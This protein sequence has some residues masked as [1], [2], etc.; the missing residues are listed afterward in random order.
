MSQKQNEK[1]KAKRRVKVESQERTQVKQERGMTRGGNSAGEESGVRQKEGR[2]GGRQ[3][4]GEERR[5]EQGLGAKHHH[6][7]LIP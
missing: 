6:Q 2:E 5:G 1:G 4:R 3:R 7:Y